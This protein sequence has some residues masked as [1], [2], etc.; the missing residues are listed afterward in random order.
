MIITLLEVDT[1][2]G[3]EYVY[4]NYLIISTVQLCSQLTLSGL[5]SLAQTNIIK[6]IKE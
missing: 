3:Y 6:I 4:K 1:D 2:E 5:Q